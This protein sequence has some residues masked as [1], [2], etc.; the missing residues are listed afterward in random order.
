LGV[1]FFFTPLL[2]PPFT[3]NPRLLAWISIRLPVG[4][5]SP[6]PEHNQPVASGVAVM[7]SFG[8]LFLL[9]TT[10]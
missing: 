8:L 9:L 2:V 1:V 5:A 4:S 10:W 6:Q 7:V 3:R